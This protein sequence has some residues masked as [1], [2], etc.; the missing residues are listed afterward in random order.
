MI[1]AQEKTGYYGMPLEKP[2]RKKT[3][4]LKNF[5]RGR[6]IALTGTVLVTFLLGVLIIYY[7][8][9]VSTLGYQISCLEKELALLRVENHSLEGDVQRL[10]SL[11]RVET[12]ALEK[13]GMVK[14]GSDNVLFVEVAGKTVQA[15]EPVPEQGA[16]GG[17]SFAGSEK[18]SRLIR[19]FTEMVYR[20]ENK[21][22]LGLGGWAG[23]TGG[24]HADDEYFNPEKN[25]RTLSDS[26]PGARRTGFSAGLDS[27]GSRG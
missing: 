25:N 19:A 18:K 20:L 26:G 15:S 14:P 7:H 11:D 27:A 2:G 24:T 6:R 23:S 21:T 17:F 4:R 22:W 5:T 9:Q 13:L 10:A 16:A 12:L 3:R 1:L 8:S